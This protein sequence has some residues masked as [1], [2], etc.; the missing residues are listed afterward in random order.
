MESV[1]ELVLAIFGELLGDSSFFLAYYPDNKIVPNDERDRRNYILMP[2]FSLIIS[3]MAI[4]SCKGFQLFLREAYHVLS[5][6]QPDVFSKLKDSVLVLLDFVPSAS[7]MYVY[8]CFYRKGRD[9]FEG[10][11]VKKGT[12]FHKKHDEFWNIYVEDGL[13]GGYILSK[14][15]Q[16]IADHIKWIIVINV[17]FLTVLHMEPVGMKIESIAH[18]QWI[19][20]LPVAMI[21]FLMEVSFFL[22]NPQRSLRDLFRRKGKPYVLDI[23]MDLLRLK[24]LCE[25]R[26][27]KDG[28]SVKVEYH[29]YDVE[30][31]N[32]IRK[33]FDRYQEIDDPSVQY[34]RTYLET[35]KF[36][37]SYH[38]H[39]IDTT[40]RLIKGENIFLASPFYRD[41]DICIFFPI[42]MSLL[43]SEKALVLMEDTGN[44]N[45]VA[46]WIKQGVEQ[47]PG[48]VDFWK[49]DILGTLVDNTDVGIMAFQNIDKEDVLQWQKEFFDKVSF[50]VIFKAS[51]IIAGGQ[52]I[53]TS[54]ASRIGRGVHQCRWLLCDRNAE[55]MIDLFSH[56]LNQEFRYV[57]ATPRRAKEALLAF[58]DLEREP[59]RPWVPV[60]R[61]LGVEA[62]IAELAG[63]EKIN[64][65]EWYGEEVAPVF[66]LRW[67]WGQYYEEYGKRTNQKNHQ[68]QIQWNIDCKIAGN[69]GCI[70]KSKFLLVE[71]YCFNIYEIGRQYTARAEDK[72]CIHVLS[73]NYMLR[74]FMKSMS[75]SMNADPKFIAQFVPEYVDSIRNIALRLIRILM[76]RAVSENE[77][78][79]ILDKNEEEIFKDITLETV[80]WLVRLIF[81]EIEKPEIVV[82][83]KSE[84]SEKKREITQ[85][86]Y[87]Q[88]IDE[89]VRK[90]FKKYFSQANYVDEEGRKRYISRLMLA[91]HLEQKYQIGQYVVF[92]GKYYEIIGNVSTDYDQSLLVK[93]A[94]DQIHGRKYYRQKRW[95]CVFD[96]SSDI[97]ESKVIFDREK[98]VIH[99]C[100]MNIEAYTYGYVQMDSWNNIYGGEHFVRPL[101]S[102]EK[103][104]YRRKQL[105]K[106]EFSALSKAS[107][108]PCWIAALLNET[109]CTFYPQYYHLISVAV[110]REHYADMGIP[111]E[112]LYTVLAG[113]DV[114]T[115][116][117]FYI[118]EDSREDIGLLRSIERNFQR[119]LDIIQMY[120]KWSKETGNEYFKFGA[121]DSR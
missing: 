48:L 26:A 31:K 38:I 13:C 62:R 20:L 1:F 75:K 105:L 115:A 60:Q 117:C 42:Y 37:S 111:D 88:I 32:E 106:V 84:F 85:I 54:F 112:I 63:Q 108:L 79:E 43:R 36:E 77:I 93:R 114:D 44:L 52:E 56:L 72:I 5:Q 95:Y 29:T 11:V 81:V 89:K 113:I 87:Y 92:D 46:E 101:N 67:V 50:V 49:V 47:I 100:F 17:V 69:T 120:V 68:L 119:I 74:D 14:R 28:A 40:V 10:I 91:G 18:F 2:L 23:K 103:R 116:G 76:D 53:V 59:Q 33:A 78:R 64:Q 6:F 3:G 110:N 55:S 7:S 118:L 98:V 22:G 58:W 102:D 34:F 90:E 104:Y 80:R 39:Y 12:N 70:T 61:Y 94:S 27:V 45:E 24:I 86:A 8:M 107:P 4:A 15:W 51:D 19:E 30:L 121:E 82:F 41:F 83:Y 9:L 97:K 65:I 25:A 71:D 109:L 35:R 16:V 96:E 57:S 73:P 21:T 99:R 66:D